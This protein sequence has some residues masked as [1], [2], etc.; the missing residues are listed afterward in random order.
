M[1]INA[2]IEILGQEQT[3]EIEV[4]TETIA[5]AALAQATST[6]VNLLDE[7]SHF[8]DN[9]RNGL[10]IEEGARRA[11]KKI[12][13]DFHISGQDDELESY[14][15]VF[16]ASTRALAAGADRSFLY[17]LAG[18]ILKGY[19][20]EGQYRG[21]PLAVVFDYRLNQSIVSGF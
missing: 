5:E 15:T 6:P 8:Y 9:G 10:T 14:L 4:P 7:D 20:D 1:K 21:L 19:R 13:Q 17:R 3:V 16:N 2:S 18:G 11:T 12:M